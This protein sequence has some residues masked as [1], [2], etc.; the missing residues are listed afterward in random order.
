LSVF[1]HTQV[2]PG[3]GSKPPT[4]HAMQL[5]RL[6]NGD[7]VPYQDTL[8]VVTHEGGRAPRAGSATTRKPPG[9]IRNESGG[10]FTS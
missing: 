9:Y 10:M 7:P 8:R 4:S 6:A 3:K 2:Q 5:Q 1:T